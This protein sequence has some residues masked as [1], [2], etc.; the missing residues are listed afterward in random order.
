MT[1]GSVSQNAMYLSPCFI[2]HFMTWYRLF[3]SPISLPVRQGK[4][5]PRDEPKSP[6]FGEH[7]DTVKYKIVVSP[8]G[9]GYFCTDDEAYL[10]VKGGG[11][12][13]LKARVNA[14][15]VDLHSRKEVIKVDSP[16]TS[17]EATKTE[18]IFH[19]VELELHDI[20]LRVVK[21]SHAKGLQTADNKSTSTSYYDAASF[22]EDD[23][24]NSTKYSFQ[25]VDSKDYVLL[26][27]VPQQNN[28][29]RRKIEIHPFAFSPLLYYIKQNDEVGTERRQYLRGTHD[30]IMGKGMGNN[31]IEIF[32]V[33]T[34]SL[35]FFVLK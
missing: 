14:F 12:A 20:D 5:F 10:D 15:S 28:L 27:S 1:S 6:S 3:G 18:R 8:L 17:D 19:E 7:L 13:G 32:L 35:T 2:K 33:A 4:L 26:D 25:W 11:S 24:E 30:C 21:S 34:S 9:I 22:D 16:T 31:D 23:D 29:S